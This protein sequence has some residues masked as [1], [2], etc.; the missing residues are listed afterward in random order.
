[1]L[2]LVFM[3]KFFI[4]L[5]GFL[6]MSSSLVRAYAQGQGQPVRIR[7]TTIKI[8]N[9]VHKAPYHGDAVTSSYSEPAAL[10]TLWFHYAAE[11]AEVLITKDEETV[12][13]ETFDMSAN[14][15]LECD[16]S[17]CE[18]G[19]YTVYVYVQGE[20]LLADCLTVME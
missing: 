13:E 4:V 20:L 19:E 15:Q 7:T 14:E 10:L 1:M 8:H 17:E 3:R 9:N 16:F 18:A 11:N 2:N 12:A 5:F 6:L